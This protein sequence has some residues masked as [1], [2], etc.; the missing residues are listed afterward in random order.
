[1]SYAAFLSERLVGQGRKPRCWGGRGERG[2][3]YASCLNFFFLTQ[4]YFVIGGPLWF[5]FMLQL[6][7]VVFLFLF[8][9]C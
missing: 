1:M 8:L 5:S 2:V 4:Q 3:L 9:L 6:I 7:I